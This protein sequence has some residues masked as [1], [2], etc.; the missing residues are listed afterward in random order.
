MYVAFKAVI[1]RVYAAIEG[2]DDTVQ[3]RT[4]DTLDQ[5]TAY[6]SEVVESTVEGD[7]AGLE[8]GTDLFDYGLDSLQAGRIRN[9]LQRVSR[10][11]C[12]A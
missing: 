12:L 6:V 9:T 3:K 1:D 5:V 11:I 8:V 4:F 2:E 7:H 10:I